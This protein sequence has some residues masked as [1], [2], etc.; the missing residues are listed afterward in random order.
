MIANTSTRDPANPAARYICVGQLG[1]SYAVQGWVKLQSFTEP[2]DA[3]LS[4][5]PWYLIDANSAVKP[6]S[7]KTAMIVDCQGN[8]Q[9]KTLQATSSKPHGR[10]FVVKF[11]GYDNPEQAR[12]LAGKYL[13]VRREQLAPLPAGEYYWIDLIGLQVENLAGDS[14]GVV[15]DLMET[16]ANDVLVV[17]S[18]SANANQ[19]GSEEILIPYVMDRYV[20][21]IDLIS[22]TMRVDWEIDD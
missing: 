12:E 20:K 15:T 1:A 8:L 13:Y 9:L 22:N 17:K 2:V 7:G 5:R 3:I 4:Y 6:V 10:S 21:S 18:A 11:P 16:G 19:Q 14:L